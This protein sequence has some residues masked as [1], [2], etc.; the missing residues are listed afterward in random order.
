[1]RE[2][3]SGT[4]I[5][6][7]PFAKP[8]NF[9]QQPCYSATGTSTGYTP[10]WTESGGVEIKSGTTAGGKKNEVYFN[11]ACLGIIASNNKA[12]TISKLQFK[13]R[14][15]GGN[16]NL[17]VNGKLY[18]CDDFA[19]LHNTLLAGGVS[20]SVNPST[21]GPKKGTLLLQGDMKE[22]KLTGSNFLS[23]PPPHSPDQKYIAVIGGGQELCIDDL[24]FTI[25]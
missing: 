16:I 11:T 5:V 6:V 13:F 9:F 1:M 22:F 23:P 24:V 10:D 19:S 7:L 12:K 14:Y 2:E 8:S 4:D 3:K 15:D 17:I 18:N 20:V 21:P 25:N